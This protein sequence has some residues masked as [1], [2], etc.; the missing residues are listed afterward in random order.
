MKVKSDDGG[1]ESETDEERMMKIYIVEV[2]KYTHIDKGKEWLIAVKCTAD[3]YQRIM[4][5]GMDE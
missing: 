2:K 3:S 5:I 1:I 4:E